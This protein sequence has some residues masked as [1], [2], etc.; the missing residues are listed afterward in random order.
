M[1]VSLAF[2][3]ALAREAGDMMRAA[4]QSKIEVDYKLS[5]SDLLTKTDLAVEQHIRSRV[6]AAFPTHQFLMEE[7][8]NP[9][10]RLSEAPTWVVDPIDGTTNFVHGLPIFTVSI[11]Y[12]VEK[13]P[14]LAVVYNPL[15]AELFS[16][17]KGKGAELNGQKISASATKQLS[18]ALVGCEFCISIM[19]KLKSLPGP[20]AADRAAEF[21]DIVMGTARTLL[22]RARDIRCFCCCSYQMCL[23]ACGRLD[24]YLAL[25]IKEWD[26]AAGFLIC[27]EAGGTV[28][29]YDG[30][31]VLREAL[32]MYRVPAAWGHA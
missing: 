12:V 25:T 22:S 19:K 32:C 26:I 20:E 16:A 5:N 3:E 6:S 15:R 7:S 24:A 1:D 18:F 2:V 31:Q 14:R 21:E 17:E 10:D 23:V 30:S 29:Q 13:T 28:T 27:A 11:A 8:S 4:L 9:G